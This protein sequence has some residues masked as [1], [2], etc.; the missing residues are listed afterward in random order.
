[1]LVQSHTNPTPPRPTPT[2]IPRP[3]VAGRRLAALR[4]GYHPVVAQVLASRELSVTDN[5]LA[6]AIH[7]GLDLL[8]HY[9]SLPGIQRAA[10]RIAAAILTGETIALETDHDVDGVTSHAVL[11]TALVEHCGHPSDKIHGYI[12]HRLRDGY[13]L[14]D[15]VVDRILDAHPMPSLVITADNGSSDEDRIKRLTEQGIDVIVTDHHEL[16]RSGPPASAYAC[17][18][19]KHPDSRYPDLNIAGCMVAWLLACAVKRE[20]QGL[21]IPAPQNTSLAPL[22]DFVALGTV[23]DCVSL[24]SSINNRAVVNAGLRRIN[25]R[26]RPCWRAMFPDTD[27]GSPITATDLAFT[28]GPR[29]NARGRLDDAMA[30][31]AF[32]LSDTDDQAREYGALLER[33]NDSR[34]AIEKQMKTQAMAAAG[35]MVAAGDT[36]IV[37]WLPD[38]HSG[39]HGI[40]ASR[41]V[42]AFGRPVVCISPKQGS[43]SLV[44]GSAR[45]VPGFHVQA[46]LQSCADAASDTDADLFVAFG[47]HEG[48][49][50]LTMEHAHIERFRSAYNIA[51][52][53]QLETQ[54]QDGSLGPAILTDGALDSSD[55]TLAVIDELAQLAPFGRGFD[56]PVF[57]GRF[58]VLAVK[59]IGDGTHL[60]LTLRPE[61]Q[62]HGAVNAVWFSA[63]GDAADDLPVAAKQIAEFAYNLTANDYRG[64]HVQLIVRGVSA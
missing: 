56:E 39:V 28:V 42:E 25:A 7:P 46:A 21:D 47:G 4:A 9:D 24:G 3:E 59:A 6:T 35:E 60:K 36:A 49:G 50:G 12:G 57:Q 14:S 51:A 34:K 62:S 43:D 13:G 45:G 23:A 26:Q 48:A 29:I 32:L 5:D 15:P 20:C 17:V 30:G 1:M 55:M 52:E 64:R 19:P 44:T 2:L 18:S 27:S 58:L 54:L 38:G 16:P 10:T 41:L 11:R 8:D 22:L 31:V 40:V 53:A 37:I 63:L 33:E 61:G